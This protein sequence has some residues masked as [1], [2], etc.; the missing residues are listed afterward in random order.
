MHWKG[1]AAGVTW[2]LVVLLAGP[3]TPADTPP[4]APPPDNEGHGSHD[5]QQ[6]APPLPRMDRTPRTVRVPGRRPG[7][8]RGSAG[9]TPLDGLMATSLEEGRGRVVAAGVSREVRPGD[10]L[11]GFV[12]KAIDARRIVLTGSLAGRGETTAIVTFDAK[13]QGRVLLFS[14]QD[15][16]SQRP[17]EA[18]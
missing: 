9:A 12:V 17:P 7:V 2:G 4:P 14:A 1:T 6:G 15:T 5:P 11:E 16:T 13:G 10:S 18:R 8:A 3:A